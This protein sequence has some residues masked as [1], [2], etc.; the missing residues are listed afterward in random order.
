MIARILAQETDIL[1]MDEP[2]AFLDIVSKFDI[3]KLMLS[4][5]SE[6]RQLSFR[7]MTSILQSIRPMGSG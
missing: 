5:A 4:L 6:G 1:I 2:T 7:R 3:I